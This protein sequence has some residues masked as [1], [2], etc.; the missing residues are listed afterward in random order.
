[1]KTLYTEKH[2]SEN[3]ERYDNMRGVI[4]P[5]EDLENELSIFNE[6]PKEALDKLDTIYAKQVYDRLYKNLMKQKNL[7]TNVRNNPCCLG[8]TNKTQETREAHKIITTF[9]FNC[10]KLKLFKNNHNL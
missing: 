8:Y 4:T 5:E 10:Y 1:M 3:I 2:Y 6:L 9:E 7:Y